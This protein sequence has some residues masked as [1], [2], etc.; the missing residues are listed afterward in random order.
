MAKKRRKTDAHLLGL[1]FEKTDGHRRITRGDNF[2]IIGGTQETHEKM[3]EKAV[4]FN[5]QLDKHG[6]QLGEL[7]KNEFM[8]I[9]GKAGLT[10]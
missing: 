4:K 3:Q 2:T 10:E 7:S 1:A 5:E 8:D 6:K 9:A